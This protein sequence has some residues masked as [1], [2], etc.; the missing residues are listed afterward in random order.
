[1]LTRRIVPCLDVKD[2]RVVK[3]VRFQGLRDAGDVAER[4][5][6]YA[7]DGADELVFLDVS[8]T[9]EGRAAT[10]D[11]VRRA[12]AALFI[13]LTV[14]G[15]VRAIDDIAR[16]LENGADKVAINSAALEDPG[17][18][19]RAAATF[20]SQCVVVAIDAALAPGMPCALPA[21]EVYGRAATRAT[22]RNA[23]AW[24]REAAERGAGEILLTSIDRDGTR[25]GYD[26][27]LTAAVAGAVPVPVVASGGA[28]RPEDVI[29]LFQATGASAALVASLVHDGLATIG[30]LKAACA[31]AGI[32]VRE[33]GV[34]R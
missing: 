10:L 30:A 9:L 32:P 6:R 34:R 3:G 13:P 19:D 27:E 12:A 21:W 29:R 7:A 24:A 22:G 8:A 11:A 1:M 18:I 4:A 2:G 20:G 25:Q 31:A 16:L 23:V 33:E 15:G 28:G 5:A 26:L 17:L 14:G